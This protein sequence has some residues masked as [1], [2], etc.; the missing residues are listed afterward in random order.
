MI[1][2]SSFCSPG[3]PPQKGDH[4]KKG[5]VTPPLG[6]FWPMP[7]S[8]D[9]PPGSVSR[10][11]SAVIPLRYTRNMVRGPVSEARRCRSWLPWTKVPYKK[12]RGAVD[13]AS[14]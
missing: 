12:P 3:N 10:A 7:D 5:K 14:K 13:G 4:P 9:S 2:L 8:S 6:P 11:A 1:R